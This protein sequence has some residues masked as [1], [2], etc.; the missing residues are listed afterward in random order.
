VLKTLEGHVPCAHGIAGNL[1]FSVTGDVE[2][3]GDIE[4]I[5]A[6]TEDCIFN[7]F[8]NTE[9]KY[10]NRVRSRV[11]NLKAS[12]LSFLTVCMCCFIQCC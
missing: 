8:R 1:A 7:E 4:A 9:V 5:A 2:A 11:A 3:V 6:A 12:M 10:K